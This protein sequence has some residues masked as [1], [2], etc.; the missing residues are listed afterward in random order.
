MISIEIK[1]VVIHIQ[2]V[3]ATPPN[4]PR[5]RRHFVFTIPFTFAIVFVSSY[6]CE[7]LAIKKVVRGGERSPTIFVLGHWDS[8][9]WALDTLAYFARTK[10]FRFILVP[11]NNTKSRHWIFLTN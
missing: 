3:S 5:N 6:K 1:V 11:K 4:N 2:Y 8:S 9:L 10:V 7:L